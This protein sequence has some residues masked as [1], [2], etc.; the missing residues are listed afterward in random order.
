MCTIRI[1]IDSGMTTCINGVRC[2][3]KQITINIHLTIRESRYTTRRR[4]QLNF[5]CIYVKLRC[6][7]RCSLAIRRVICKKCSNFLIISGTNGMNI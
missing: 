4:I 7:L 5:L 2:I 1:D 6:I 3:H